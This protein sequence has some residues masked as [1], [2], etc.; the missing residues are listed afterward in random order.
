MLFPLLTCGASLLALTWQVAH[1]RGI[2]Q[3]GPDGYER[4]PVVDNPRHVPIAV[5]DETIDSSGYEDNLLTIPHLAQTPSHPHRPSHQ[6]ISPAENAIFEAA[7]PKAEVALVVL[8]ILAVGAQIIIHL[9]MLL[10]KALGE[11][12]FSATVVGLGTWLYILVLVAT[13]LL[14]STFPQPGRPRLWNHTASLYGFQWFFATITL[15]SAIIH[16]RSR[17]AQGLNIGSFVLVTALVLMVLTT[18]RGN[19]CVVV[20]H[21]PG[22]QPSKEP[23]ASLASRATFSW[24]D[25]LVWT[26]YK[27]NITLVD[28]PDLASKYKAAGLIQDFRQL[29]YVMRPMSPTM[30]AKGMRLTFG[31]ERP[32]D[33][34]GTC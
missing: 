7:K 30:V 33:S 25:S 19:R 14:F 20:A 29:K 16:P 28:V 3:K 22:L 34:P 32:R 26:G 13:R 18:R 8:E 4:L 12:G 2:S 21:D 11:D 6:T 27:N 23:L 9:F 31:L 24:V 17:L 5:V 15:R 1:P 10:T